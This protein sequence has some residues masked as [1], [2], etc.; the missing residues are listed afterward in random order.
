[1]LPT[2]LRIRPE[3][4]GYEFYAVAGTVLSDAVIT[5]PRSGPPQGVNQTVLRY[6]DLWV[7]Q[8][9]GTEVRLFADADQMQVREGHRVTL[10]VAQRADDARYVVRVW[11]HD[12]PHYSAV[13][14][15]SL[16]SIAFDF[17]GQTSCTGLPGTAIVGAQLILAVI[18]SLL[19]LIA[20]FLAAGLFFAATIRL[21]FRRGER[22]RGVRLAREAALREHLSAITRA[23][24]LPAAGG[25]GGAGPEG[26]LR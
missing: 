13:V 19:G 14:E 24:S 17:P 10:V 11:N 2:P 9:D 8:E 25:G 1:M 26:A 20:G 3:L 23:L 4:P 16:T 22:D 18:G 6:H 5:S 7:R 12:A 15:S 21:W